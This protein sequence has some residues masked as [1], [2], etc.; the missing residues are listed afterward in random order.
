MVSHV[1]IQI[2]T[3][4]VFQKHM[5]SHVK[6]CGNITCGIMWFFHKGRALKCDQGVLLW[7]HC[8]IMKEISQIIIVVM[9]MFP[10]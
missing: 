10:K 5:V 8:A 7:E 6:T 1:K 4:D 2:T 9:I 3:C